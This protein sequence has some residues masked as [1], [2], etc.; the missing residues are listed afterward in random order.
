MTHWC[1]S[2]LVWDRRYW[3]FV[4]SYV[5]LRREYL[6]G[7]ICHAILP[8][9]YI[10]YCLNIV[11]PFFIPSCWDGITCYWNFY[12]LEVISLMVL[13]AM[14][15]SFWVKWVIFNISIDKGPLYIMLLNL[16]RII[17]ISLKP[18]L[19]NTWFDITEIVFSF[20]GLQVYSSSFF[21][22]TV[23]RTAFEL[24]LPVARLLFLFLLLGLVL[25]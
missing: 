22:I 9:R 14:H 10:F 16:I 24:N 17:E 8:W 3:D 1:V 7:W 11:R 5:W 2:L 19:F 13:F 6:L 20:L 15:M 25:I 12:D 4:L 18:S 23:I 21:D